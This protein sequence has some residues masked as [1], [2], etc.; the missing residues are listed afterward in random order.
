[1]LI[2]FDANKYEN[3]IGVFR[4]Y[5]DLL[6]MKVSLGNVYI[7]IPDKSIFHCIKQFLKYTTDSFRIVKIR[8]NKTKLN[9][10][11]KSKCE[12]RQLRTKES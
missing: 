5:I 1:M 11:F 10:M 9:R 6:V 3:G 8:N 12:P 4:Y 2:S 7:Y